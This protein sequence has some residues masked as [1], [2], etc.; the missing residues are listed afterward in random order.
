[1]NIIF[2]RFNKSVGEIPQGA[3]GILRMNT[4]ANDID[5]SRVFIPRRYTGL[6]K[7]SLPCYD[8]FGV[9]DW[10]EVP[11][12]ALTEQERQ[13]LIDLDNEIANKS[14][15]LIGPD[16]IIITTVGVRRDNL[17]ALLEKALDE[18]DDEE[19]V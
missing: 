17:N 3:L 6:G 9:E 12:A 18:L 1:M 7:D 19:E 8:M 2:I 16:G 13:E 5:R 11:E 4:M 15:I 10:V 14:D